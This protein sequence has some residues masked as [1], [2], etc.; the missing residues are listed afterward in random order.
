[1]QRCVGGYAGFGARATSLGVLWVFFLAPW[2]EMRDGFLKESR[3]TGR[4][5]VA[6]SRF[7]ALFVL[8]VLLANSAATVLFEPQWLIQ[9]SILFP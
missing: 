4:V 8:F 6:V 3:S 9:G 5:K 1:M 7:P 2:D